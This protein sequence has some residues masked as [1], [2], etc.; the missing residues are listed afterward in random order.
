MLEGGLALLAGFFFFFHGMSA[1]HVA[2]DQV[3]N[4]PISECY[5][6]FVR[7]IQES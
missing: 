2:Q 7:F 6:L 1:P 3:F 5:I 4:T